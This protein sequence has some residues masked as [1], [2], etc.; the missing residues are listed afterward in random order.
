MNAIRVVNSYYIIRNLEIRNTNEGV[1]LERVTGVVFENNDVHHINNEGI[2]LHF[3]AVSN[4]V[5]N[6]RVYDTGLT[7][8]GE[9]IYIGTAPEQRYK[10]GGL[11]DTSTHN[12]ISGNEIYGTRGEAIDIKEDSSYTTIE[13]NVVH[14]VNAP[15]SGGM[16]IRSD[17]NYLYGN[18]SRDND[19]AGFRFG[20]DI[21]YSPIYGNNY[22]Y[23]LNNVLRNNVANNNAGYGYKF[24]AGPQD[25]NLSNTG[26]GNGGQLYYY[27][28]GVSPFV[29]AGL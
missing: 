21:V 23:G 15:N 4:I 2:R 20:G 3:F 11:P 16:C 27:G 19:G 26:F 13:N 24:M 12:I 29:S 18:I 28:S 10:N 8:N 17:Q 5:R 25:A 7:S 1:R 9:G 6:S 22:H 14:N